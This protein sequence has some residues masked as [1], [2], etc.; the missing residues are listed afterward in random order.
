MQPQES[1]VTY[2]GSRTALADVVVEKYSDSQRSTLFGNSYE[3]LNN[4][5]KATDELH[6]K[7][8]IIYGSVFAFGITF[9]GIG[10]VLNYVYTLKEFIGVVGCAVG[11][12]AGWVSML[13][14]ALS[15]CHATKVDE[16]RLTL[17]AFHFAAKGLIM[18]HDSYEN[19]KI[20]PDPNKVKHLFKCFDQLQIYSD[21]YIYA[22][23]GGYSD[24]QGVIVSP[25]FIKLC[26][27]TGKVFLMDAVVN[28]LKGNYVKVW[29]Q[30]LQSATSLT[31]AEKIEPW[32]SFKIPAPDL[33]AHNNFIQ[34]S[35]LLKSEE[36]VEHILKVYK[37]SLQYII[38]S[39]PINFNQE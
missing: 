15:C 35:Q 26:R 7:V 2:N 6:A 13:A 18:L 32:A 8:R 12:T 24:N 27:S 28:L 9:A 23:D 25:E 20:I 39:K 16:R 19:F 4:Q 5:V 17:D 29:Q 30:T 37:R 38:Q 21:W 31:I 10:G 34:G 22:R 33:K 14:A 1:L 36:F 11:V 3:M